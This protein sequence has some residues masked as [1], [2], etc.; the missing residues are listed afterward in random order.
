[1]SRY[2]VVRPVIAAY[3]ALLE[4]DGAPLSQ[5]CVLMLDLQ[6][7]IALLKA[8]SAQTVAAVEKISIPCSGYDRALRE[9]HSLAEQLDVAIWATPPQ[10]C[11]EPLIVMADARLRLM[12][13]R[14]RVE[15]LDPTPKRKD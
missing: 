15:A 12:K 13:A 5:D 6:R 9:V 1:M 7:V 2:E 14:L 11:K 8:E 4:G 3:D 10:F